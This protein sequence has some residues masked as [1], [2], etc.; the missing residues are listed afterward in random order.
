MDKDV[1]VSFKAIISSKN[2]QEDIIY[3]E[4]AHNASFN[5]QV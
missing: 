3:N 2:G 1:G 5:G 4:I